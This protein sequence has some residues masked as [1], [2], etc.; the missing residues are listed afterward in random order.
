AGTWPRRTRASPRW[1]SRGAAPT[2]PLPSRGTT[3]RRA[4][5][6]P[7]TRT[8][9]GPVRPSRHVTRQ[10]GMPDDVLAAVTEEEAGDDAFGE[11]PLA[12]DAF[13]PVDVAARGDG[14]E[15]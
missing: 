2:A 9:A 13:E 10:A 1:N 6:G 15:R 12:V 4:D 14:L 5:R 3:A 7:R 11:P 8:A